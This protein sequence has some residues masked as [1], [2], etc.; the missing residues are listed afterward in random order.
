[1]MGKFLASGTVLPNFE[2]VVKK[3]WLYSDQSVNSNL[4]EYLYVHSGAAEKLRICK[5]FEDFDI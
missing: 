1:M 2:P 4:E 3:P 5:R